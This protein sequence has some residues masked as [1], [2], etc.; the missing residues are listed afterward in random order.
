MVVQPLTVVTG[1]L[2]RI[3]AVINASI[4][5]TIIPCTT[6]AMMVLLSMLRIIAYLFSRS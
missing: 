3:F 1:A 4:P 5:P 2:K 6:S